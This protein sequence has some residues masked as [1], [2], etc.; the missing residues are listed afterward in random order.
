MGNFCAK[1]ITHICVVCHSDDCNA[2]KDL[3]GRCEF[4]HKFIIE[5]G[6]QCLKDVTVRHEQ[7]NRPRALSLPAPPP[8]QP[9]PQAT[10]RHRPRVTEMRSVWSEEPHM[11]PPPTT[12]MQIVSRA[13][14]APPAMYGFG[15]HPPPPPD[16]Q[17][18]KYGC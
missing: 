11:T 9:T 1:K 4:I 18:E 14:S 16:Y 6:R 3:C 5:H 8:P 17:H 10:I 13:P 12:T 15:L 2:K 7:Q